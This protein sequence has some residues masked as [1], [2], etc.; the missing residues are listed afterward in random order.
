MQEHTEKIVTQ[1]ALKHK[2]AMNA[3]L[4]LAVMVDKD[5]TGWS[6]LETGVYT[7]VPRNG[8]PVGGFRRSS[9]ELGCWSQ[10]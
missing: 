6:G 7:L 9:I 5:A 2:C 3:Y 8:S 1:P 4:G 10:T